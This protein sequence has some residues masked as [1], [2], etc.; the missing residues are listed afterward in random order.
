MRLTLLTSGYSAMVGVHS[1][2]PLCPLH[3]ETIQRAIVEQFD[4]D[5]VYINFKSDQASL[6][7]GVKVV[8]EQSLLMEL[9]IFVKQKV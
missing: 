3:K 5:I 6:S 2:A 9:E 1:P 4:K 8:K 7:F